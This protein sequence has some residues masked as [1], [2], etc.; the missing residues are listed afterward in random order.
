MYVCIGIY[1]YTY[2]YISIFTTFRHVSFPL[3]VFSFPLPVFLP[4]KLQK[5]TS[6]GKEVVP[7]GIWHFACPDGYVA[8]YKK[9]MRGNPSHNAPLGVKEL[10]DGTSVPVFPETS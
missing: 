6:E 4:F 9:Y 7:P 5:A 2:I 1:V 3:R 10:A 8:W